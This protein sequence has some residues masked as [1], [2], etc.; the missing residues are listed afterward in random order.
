[1]LMIK[2][3]SGISIKSCSPLRNKAPAGRDIN[4]GNV[5][6]K[7]KPR[8]V[9]QAPFCPESALEGRVHVSFQPSEKSI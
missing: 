1:M 8:K 9:P 4:P 7:R 5:S 6:V 2:V 3:R